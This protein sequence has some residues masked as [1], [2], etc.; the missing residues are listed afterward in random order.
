MLKV[1]HY[2][3]VDGLTGCFV[4]TSQ[5][6]GG[7]GCWTGRVIY[8]RFASPASSENVSRCKEFGEYPTESDILND[9]HTWIRH[10]LFEH[11]T[12]AKMV[13]DAGLVS[14]AASDAEI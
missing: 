10:S 14:T 11:W 12:S 1:Y 7:N 3:S 5:L 8:N 13:D 2:H 4:I 9:V 6:H